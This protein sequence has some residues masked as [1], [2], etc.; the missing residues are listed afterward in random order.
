MFHPSSAISCV[1]L[2]SEMT[3]TDERRHTGALISAFVRRATY[4]RDIEQQ[5]AF[6]VDARSAC[7]N[8]D[9]VFV[10]LVHCVNRLATDARRHAVV[11]QPQHHQQ[12]SRKI[13]AFTKACAA[14]CYI[15]IP[16]IV[17]VSA[18]MDLYLLSGQVA[19]QNCCLGQADACFE[20][21]LN[22][23]G[24]L[25][26]TLNTTDLPQWEAVPSSATSSS[27]RSSDP[28]LVA[29]LCSF[30]GTLLVVP[31]SPERGALYLVRKLLQCVE[32][33]RW[34]GVGCGQAQAVYLGALDMLAAA[35][36]DTYP[37]HIVGVVSNDEL[38]GAGA[39]FLAEVDA[40][41]SLVAEK[42]LGQ[43]REL[44][45]AQQQRAQA[46]L[47]MEMFGRCVFGGDVAREKVATLATNL[48]SLAMKNR[49][50]LDGKLPV[51]GLCL[52]LLFV[53]ATADLIL[54][55]ILR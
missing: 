16:S 29:Y 6:Y 24:E 36:Q 30:L 12:M 31:D 48:W 25:P 28:Y 13:H 37:Y 49:V 20:A 44:G 19:L 17:A 41:G 22:L 5:L 45:E 53:L 40:L 52:F 8:L 34:D 26:R 39:K 33:V 3:G 9:A 47:A 2:N 50:A 46:Q 51:S 38:Y 27:S 11:A 1:P 15:T 43:L 54:V 21:A 42:L 14:Y 10:T 35:A 32:R 23:V 7:P 55:A 18:R 4:G